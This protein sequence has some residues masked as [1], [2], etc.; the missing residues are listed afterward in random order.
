MPRKHDVTGFIRSTFRSVWALELLCFLQKNRARAWPQAEL[1]AALRASELIVAQSVAGLA[2][3]GLIVIEEDGAV[4]YQPATTDLD[5]LAGEA[6]AVY[7]RSPDAVRRLIISAA[8][9]DLTAFAD[10][11]KVRRD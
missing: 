5:A 6:E 3:A 4:R 8:S 9:G 2:A 10:A 11:F 1:V 7:A